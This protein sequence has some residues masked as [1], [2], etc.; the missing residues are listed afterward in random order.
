[1]NETAGRLHGNVTLDIVLVMDALLP[2]NPP[3][4]EKLTHPTTSKLQS[5]GAAKLIQSEGVQ[6]QRTPSAEGLLIWLIGC[7]THLGKLAHWE[8]Q[9]YRMHLV[10]WAVWGSVF[11]P[12]KTWLFG[13]TLHEVGIVNEGKKTSFINLKNKQNSPFHV[14]CLTCL[15]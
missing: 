5:P 11:L 3:C 9:N 2:R 10:G 13:H 14:F 6:E 15:N 4:G 1:M 8:T 7:H 12:N